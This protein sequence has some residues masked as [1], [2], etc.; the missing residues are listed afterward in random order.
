MSSIIPAILEQSRE[1]FDDKHFV[2][3][4]IIGVERIHIDFSDGI[5]VPNKTISASELDVLNPAFHYE[6]HL[7]IQNPT[8]FVDY[9]IAGV[10]TVIVHYEAFAK[11]EMVDEAALAI[12]KLG[13]T[14]AVAI[15][16]ETS[17]SVLRY[18]GDTISHFLIMGVHPGAQGNPFIDETFDRISELRQMFPHATIEVDGGVNSSNAHALISAGA[19]FLVV[20]SAIVSSADPATSFAQ[21]ESSILTETKT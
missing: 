3:E 7:M 19:N 12:S 13:I 11:E 9:N 1:S 6:A 14:P 2:I 15:N 18:F 5:F 17:I 8:D 10:K 20:G 16:P 4:R 21:I